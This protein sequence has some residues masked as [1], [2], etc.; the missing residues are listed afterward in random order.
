MSSNL[1]L[2]YL[3]ENTVPFL[4]KWFENHTIHIHITKERN[5]KLGDYRKKRD[6]SHMITVNSTLEP[7]LFFFVLTHE[8]A[9]LLSFERY[10][11]RIAP[12]GKEWKFVFRT[13]LLES[14]PVYSKD[15]QSILTRFSVSP[16]ANFMSSEELVRYFYSEPVN[17][18]Y[19]FVENLSQNEQFIYRKQ[20]YQYNERL[21]KNYL[22]TN[23]DSGKK[24]LFK[25]L[26]QVEKLANNRHE[27]Q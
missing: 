10:G 4:K 9:H 15:L 5:T 21:K 11:G 16:K 1:L 24:Y 14:M 20:R 26:V 3:P 18:S 23:L 7:E 27:K 2:K 19:V 22:C 12:H 13:M 6:G 25:S 17:E 8:L